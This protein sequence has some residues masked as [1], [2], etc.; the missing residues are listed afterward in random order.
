MAVLSLA[1]RGP[2]FLLAI[3]LQHV[4]EIVPG[5]SGQYSI[6]PTRCGP[7]PIG[8]VDTRGMVSRTSP[9]QL[10]VTMIKLLRY[11]VV[12]KVE[13]MSLMTSDHAG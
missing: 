7:D 12:N 13:I 1:P 10:F 9:A 3:Q 6:M 2:L 4:G 5:L 11:L 8:L